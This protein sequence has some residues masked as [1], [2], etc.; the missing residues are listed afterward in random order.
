MMP[1][2]VGHDGPVKWVSVEDIGAVAA[3][4]SSRRDELVGRDV[5]IVGDV[6]TISEPRE[7][8]RTVDG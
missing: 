1:K 4:V 3:P 7:R 8:L 6:K 5:P 2:L